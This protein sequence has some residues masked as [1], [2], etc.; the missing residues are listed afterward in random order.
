MKKI[1]LIALAFAIVGL[2]GCNTSGGDGD[3]E[4]ANQATKEAEER[5][6]NLSQQDMD[7]VARRQAEAAMKQ[8]EAMK[9]AGDAQA[10]AMRKAREAGA[11]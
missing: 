11:K 5:A 7:P 9:A 3:V 4:K 8:Q 10:E 1:G 2:V 6:K